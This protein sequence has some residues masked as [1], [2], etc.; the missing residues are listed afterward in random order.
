MKFTVVIPAAGIGKRVG[1]DIPK[2]YLKIG[3]KTIIE[4][5]LAPFI[6]HPHVQRIIVSLARNDVWFKNLSIASHPKIKIVEG[7]AERVDSVLAAL[8]KIDHKDHVLVHDAAR[9]CLQK[10]DLDKLIKHVLKTKQGAILAS[11][12]HDTMKR[13]DANNNI[14]KT[15]PRESLWHALTPQMFNNGL[16]IKA[17]LAMQGKCDI[18]DEAS[19]MEFYGQ[20]VQ[21][22]EGRSDNIKVT[23]F[24]DL[25]L[26][27]FYLK[28]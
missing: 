10:S 1:G 14:I 22:V 8:H 3:A 27:E 18:T 20:P 11:K 15:V 6:A 12:V 19:A 26:A 4:Y 9:P 2:Q 16:L 13:S 25:K 28:G 5:S 17:I 24:E 23:R 7:G 21:L